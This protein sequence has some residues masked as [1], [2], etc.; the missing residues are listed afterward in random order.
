MVEQILH[1]QADRSLVAN[2]L[3]DPC[4]LTSSG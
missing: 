4:E 2:P 1:S 3:A